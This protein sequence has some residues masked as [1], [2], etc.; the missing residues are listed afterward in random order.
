MDKL[1]RIWEVQFWWII[2]III[3][4][5]TNNYEGLQELITAET[6]REN[7][8]LETQTDQDTY[9]VVTGFSAKIRTINSPWWP[10]S[11]VVGIIK[12]EPGSS[13]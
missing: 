9:P 12:Y 11:N 6:H 7:K 2:T 13:I 10:G 8:V 3:V 1:L 4:I 5:I